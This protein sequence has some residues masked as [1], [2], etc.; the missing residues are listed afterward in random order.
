MRQIPLLLSPTADL[1]LSLLR[2]LCEAIQTFTKFLNDVC[3]SSILLGNINCPVKVWWSPKIAEAVAKRRKVLKKA[4][5]S[6]KDHKTI[7]IFLDIPRLRSLKQKLSHG[8]KLASVSLLKPVPMKSSVYSTSFQVSFPPHQHLIFP[9]FQ[10]VTF[11]YIVQTVFLHINNPTSLLKYQNPNTVP[12]V[13]TL[14]KSGPLTPI[15]FTH[16]LLT[17]H[18]LRTFLN[19]LTTLKINFF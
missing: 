18:N 2:S 1:L 14:T 12:N 15:F 13:S 10:A 5:C 4:H 17:L 6:K 3:T 9:I 7:S 19:S 8:R 11:P 16:F